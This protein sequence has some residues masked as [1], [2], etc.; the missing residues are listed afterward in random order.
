MDTTYW[1][2]NFGV[3][4]L[5]DENTKRILWHKFIK[6]KETLSDYQEGIQWLEDN[7]FQIDGIVCD[8]LR[9]MFQLFSR[10]RVQMCIFHQYKITERYLTKRPV[11]GPS[12]ELSTIVKLLF[13]TDKESFIGLFEEWKVKWADFLKER[14]IN[15]Q[16]G[17]SHY[18]HKR[19]RSTYLSL[20][21]NMPYLWTWYDSIDIGIPATNNA[22][23][24]K[25]ADLKSKLRNHNGLSKRSRQIFITEYFK[26]TFL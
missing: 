24:G 9:G 25:F 21:R 15:P 6:K 20:N 13:H 4:V 1:G 12:Q 18:I 2:R 3:V 8:G 10:Y 19:L 17:K 5:K 11:L 26:K 16:T 22:L 23:E 7:G 14:H